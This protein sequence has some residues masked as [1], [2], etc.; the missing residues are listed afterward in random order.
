[1]L[2]NLLLSVVQRLFMFM[3]D[4]WR[5]YQWERPFCPNNFLRTYKKRSC[6]NCVEGKPY[7]YHVKY[8]T[9]AHPERDEQRIEEFNRML[10]TGELPKKSW[11]DTAQKEH[12]DPKMKKYLSTFYRINKLH[13]CQEY[14]ACEDCYA[15]DK[16]TVDTYM[17]H[18]PEGF[19]EIIG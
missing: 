3:D 2:L 18:Y 1:M 19:R 12:P 11:M 15:I 6:Y 14:Y 7:I 16:K 10:I 9:N 5:E 8:F 17:D 13:Y 4:L